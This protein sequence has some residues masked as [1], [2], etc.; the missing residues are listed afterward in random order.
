[1]RSIEEEKQAVIEWLMHPS[2]LGSKPKDIKFTKQFRTNDG[3]D[4]MIFK[5]KKSLLSPWLLAI[6]SESGIFSEMQKYNQAT[7]VVD[8]TKL[9]D[10][11][12]QYWKNKANEVQEREEKAKNAGVFAGFVLLKEAC[13]DFSKFEKDFYDEWGI[14]LS[15]SDQ[16]N[17]MTKAYAVADFGEKAILALSLVES[18]VPDGEAEQN[19]QYNYMWREAVQVA[20]SHKAHLIVSV[21]DAQNPKVGGILFSMALAI[22]CRDVNTL[23]VYYNNVVVQPEYI[24][25]GNEFLKKDQFP[26][27]SLVW[28]GL[29]KSDKGVSAYTTGL[30]NLGKDEIEIV[31]VNKNPNEIRELLLNIASYVIEEDIILHAGETIGEDNTQ[32]LRIVKSEGVNVEGESLKILYE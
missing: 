23:G 3:I 8:A 10:F 17:N 7:E 20:K 19:A 9:V 14:T 4:C 31:D 6:A 1:M 15:D 18:P 12:A 27:L 21:V 32:R 26:I 28:F 24:F 22:V 16:N 2:E 11:L 13:C 29:S 5:Y 25:A 30:R